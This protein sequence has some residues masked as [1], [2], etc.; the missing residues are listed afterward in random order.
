MYINTQ[1]NVEADEESRKIN[2]DTEWELSDWAFQM[3]VHKLGQPDIDLFASRTNTKCDAYVSWKRDP[4]ALTVDAF[5][6]NWRL[7]YFYAFPPFSLIL[8]CIR[9]IINDE[10]TGILVFPYW[11][12]QPWFPLFKKVSEIVFFKPNRDLLHSHFRSRHPLYRNLT[13][14][15]TRLSGLL[16]HGETSHQ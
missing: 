7:H 10:A 12:R 15:V 2:I 1:D 4:D 13:L 14:G 6:I 8:K 5:T 9:K 11:T 3:I 16:L